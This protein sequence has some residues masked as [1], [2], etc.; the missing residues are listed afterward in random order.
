MLYYS[1]WSGEWQIVMVKLGKTMIIL[2][3]RDSRWRLTARCRGYIIGD[4]SDEGS[5]F[6]HHELKR[7][8]SI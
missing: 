8:I 3:Y 6:S 7:E 5:R 1:M 4:K 2:R